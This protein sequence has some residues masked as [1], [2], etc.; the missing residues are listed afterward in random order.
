MRKALAASGLAIVAAAGLAALTLSQANAA[1][2]ATGEVEVARTVDNFQLVDQNRKA[3]E[4]AYFRY[5]PAIVIMTQKN[6]DAYSRSAA[7]AFEAMKA[8]YADKGVLF[9]MLNSDLADARDEVRAEAE[10]LGLTTPVLLDEQQLVGEQLGVSRAGEVFVIE[11]KTL[12]VVY[13]GPLDDRFAK[14]K[15]KLKAKVKAAHAANAVD[16]LIS[17]ATIDPVSLSTPGAA[18]A[19][20]ERDR[21]AEFATISYEK[22]VAPILE[23]KCVT[24]HTAGGIGPFAMNSYQVVKGFAPMIRETIRTDRMPPYFADPHIGEFKDDQALTGE[25]IKTLVHWIEAGAPRGEGS[26]PLAA[27]AKPA[28]VWPEQLGEPDYVVDIP[29]FDVPASGIVEYQNQVVKNPFKEDKWLRAVAIVPGERGVLHHVVSGHSRDDDM[30]SNLPAGSVGSYTPGA[31]PQIMA[32][33]WGAPIPAGGAFR[34]QMHYTTT[35]K[36]ATD[37]TRVG[38]WFHDKTPPFIK[39]SAVISDFSLSIPA[40]AQRHEEQAYME[41]PADAILYTLYPHA[42]LRGIRVELEAIYPDGTREML[43][44]LPK[45]DFNWQRDYDLIEPK[46]IPAGTKL[47]SHWTYDNSGHN[48]ANPDPSINVTWGEQTHEEMMY[49]RINYRWVDETSSNVRNDLQSS[50]QASI[51]RGALDDNLDGKIQAAELR[52]PALGLKARFDTLDKDKD[53]A[54][55]AEEFA[56]AGFDRRRARQEEDPDL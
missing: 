17:G 55:S 13:H 15:P 22:D 52:G 44:S 36:P 3:H 39:R 33:G 8:A 18:I 31:Q 4:I 54:L 32:E 42:H 16:A 49:F 24:C 6:G 51:F 35:G 43:L 21:K 19:F 10:V 38:F 30:V 5:A 11:P 29:A 23:A 46:R 48:A 28:P 1:G 50:L 34:F 14:A 37:R 53:G 41:F 9:Y 40:N 7:K 2:T 27:H 47:V 20:P 56:S 25:E 26:D 12:K 45:Y